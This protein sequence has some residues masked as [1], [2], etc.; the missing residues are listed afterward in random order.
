M[1]ILY[2]HYNALEEAI[3][4]GLFSH[5]EK[6]ES[7]ETIQDIIEV[8][9]SGRFVNSEK[10]KDL[11]KRFRWDC[12]WAGKRFFPE[13]LM[14]ELYEYLDD[15]HIDTALRKICPQGLERKF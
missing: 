6:M 2:K 12:F 14:P 10:T 4:K 7:L 9:E 1:K 5:I 13:N 8:Y 3:Y 11:N 15:S